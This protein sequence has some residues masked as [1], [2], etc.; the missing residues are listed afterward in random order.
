MANKADFSWGQPTVQQLKDAGFDGVIRYLSHDTTGK[1]LSSQEAAEYLSAGLDVRVVWENGA[2]NALGG[3]PAGVADAQSALG[4]ANSL[5]IPASVALYF[6]VDFD[7]TPAQQVAINAYFS[8]IRSVL[9]SRKLGGYGGYYVIQRLEAAGLID[10]K[11]QT[12]AWSGGQV[13]A[14]ANMLQNAQSAIGGEVDVDINMHDDGAAWVAGST[15]TP[16]SPQP[17]QIQPVAA[18][19]PIQSPGAG[20][21]YTVKSGDTLSGIGAKLNVDWRAIA[22]INGIGSP[23][24]IFPNQVLTLPGGGAPAPSTISSN[25]YV[26]QSGDTLSAIASHLGISWPALAQA[27]GIAA[28]YTIYPNQILVLP[29]SSSA[30]V[31]ASGTYTVESG[32]TLSGIG[33]KTGKTWQTIASLNGIATPFLIYPGQVLRL[34]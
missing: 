3:Q 17:A 34:P 4:L 24:T 32:D 23:F 28:P 6:A 22:S 15:V 5:G 8:G 14:D 20:G 9:G 33:E 13:V 26:V 10:V 29:G 12:V 2:Q 27:N 19:D 30:P 1:N 11:W 21:K 31:A 18:P 25:H 7:A 16:G